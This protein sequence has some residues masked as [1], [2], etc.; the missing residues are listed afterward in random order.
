MDPKFLTLLNELA[1]NLLHSENLVP[2]K[3]GG[4][5]I[6][7]KNLINFFQGYMQIF[8]GGTIP[9]VK[10]MFQVVVKMSKLDPEGNLMLL[11]GDR[12]RQQSLNI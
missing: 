11:E 5:T 7:A 10:S 4:Q 9:E 12:R 1:V 2:K 3:V 8:Q 6:R